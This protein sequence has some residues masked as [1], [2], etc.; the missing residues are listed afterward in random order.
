MPVTKNNMMAMA[1]ICTCLPNASLA[2]LSLP[3]VLSGGATQA[4]CYG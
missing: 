1:T 4:D 2:A 3:L